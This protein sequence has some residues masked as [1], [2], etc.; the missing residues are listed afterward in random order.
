ML[1]LSN[2]SLRIFKFSHVT[3]HRDTDSL[4]LTRRSITDDE[5]YEVLSC[6]NQAVITE[7]AGTMVDMI[8]IHMYKHF[9]ETDSFIS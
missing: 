1:T 6:K 2:F 4:S 3:L 9:R 5:I 7:T 8:C